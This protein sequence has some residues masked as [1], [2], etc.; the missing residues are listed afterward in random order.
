MD[1]KS[2]NICL[3]KFAEV[4]YIVYTIYSTFY[5]LCLGKSQQALS[6][7]YSTVPG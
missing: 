3:H 1:S 4:Y 5:T 7:G 2:A 6:P